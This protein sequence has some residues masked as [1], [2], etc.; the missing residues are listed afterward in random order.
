MKLRRSVSTSLG[1]LVAGAVGLPLAA[2]SASA[3]TSDAESAV[4]LT[5]T[6]LCVYAPPG[7]PREET[8]FPV[9]AQVALDGG[10]VDVT[11]NG[12]PNFPRMPDIF[13]WR[14]MELRMPVVLNAETDVWSEGYLDYGEE[15]MH[16]GLAGSTPEI[17][18]PDLSGSYDT[19]VVD[20]RSVQMGNLTLN[21]T[22]T[23]GASPT[24][25]DAEMNCGLQG[26]MDR[27]V[28]S[29]QN[30][31]AE[32]TVQVPGAAAAALPARVTSEVDVPARG[33]VGRPLTMGA[34]TTIVIDGGLGDG[35]APTDVTRVEAA[36]TPVATLGGKAATSAGSVLTWQRKFGGRDPVGQPV[37][38]FVRFA[39]DTPV[40]V[41]PATVGTQSA[42]LTGFRGTATYDGI[43]GKTTAPITCT[44]DSAQD[45][46][47]V[48]VEKAAAQATTT[49]VKSV[50]RGKKKVAKITVTVSGKAN[51]KA[52]VVVTGGAKKVTRTITVKN[53]KGTLTL[54]KAQLRKKGK[55]T[56]KVT[57]KKNAEF[58]KSSG[59]STFRV[60]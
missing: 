25:Y 4:T 36:V 48:K 47:M 52:S 34:D 45:L 44:L 40:K 22:L 31:N 24:L 3:E 53:G 8:T 27:Q 6:Y 58:K 9:E 7:Q 17:P 55:Y 18:M 57:F 43:A 42:T 30:T 5:Q 20:A 28:A 2:I 46:G 16:D 50:Y 39:G 26:V 49:K 1:V 35:L 33:Q 15:G 60:K 13:T 11:L 23:V 32:C 38:H 41:T 51:G 10:N 12:M 54:K 29:L 21:A 14:A 37:N 19:S 56:V 59:R